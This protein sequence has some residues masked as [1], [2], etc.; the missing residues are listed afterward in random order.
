[1]QTLMGEHLMGTRQE[2]SDS[3]LQVVLLTCK[4][5]PVT[6]SMA[7]KLKKT[8][9]CDVMDVGEEPLKDV[10]AVVEQKR[11]DWKDVAY[12]GEELPYFSYF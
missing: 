12:M 9:G 7:D 6:Q 2:H 4:E 5:D 8:M 10:Q 11:L 3:V 1:M